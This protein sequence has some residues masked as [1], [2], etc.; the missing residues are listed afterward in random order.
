MKVRKSFEYLRLKFIFLNLSPINRRI[1]KRVNELYK[2]N[3]IISN[4]NDVNNT[5]SE[6]ELINLKILFR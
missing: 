1:I 2:N 3:N 6:N 5:E 4:I